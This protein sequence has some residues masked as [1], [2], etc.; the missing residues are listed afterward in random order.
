MVELRIKLTDQGIGVSLEDR[1]NLFSA[2]FKT[3]DA[4]SRSINKVSHGLG[5]NIC[6]TIAKSL[7]GDLILNN[8]YNQGA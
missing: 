7:G 6:K 5:L 4:V 2:Y 8:Y 3:K 1:L